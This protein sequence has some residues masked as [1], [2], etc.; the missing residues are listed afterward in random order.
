MNIAF[1]ETAESGKSFLK[2]NAFLKQQALTRILHE[3]NP[4]LVAR[5]AVV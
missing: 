2:K 3:Q 4:P 5:L 1:L